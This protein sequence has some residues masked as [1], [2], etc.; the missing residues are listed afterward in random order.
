MNNHLA[1]NVTELSTTSRSS[2]LPAP[3][4]P[5]PVSAQPTKA[6]GVH[7]E[8]G[9]ELLERARARHRKHGEVPYPMHSRN[10]HLSFDAINHILFADIV[11][12]MSLQKLE[13]PPKRVLDLGCGS[14]TWIIAAANAWPETTFV[15]FDVHTRQPN[16]SLLKRS[17]LAQRIEWV[18][19]NFLEFLPFADAEFDFVRAQSIGLGVPEDEWQNVIDEIVRVLKP[20][21][22]LE[23]IEEDILFPSPDTPITKTP[24]ASPTLRGRMNRSHSR[25]TQETVHSEEEES[26][27][28]HSEDNVPSE[29]ARSMDTISGA[30][31]DQRDHSK[32]KEAFMQMLTSRFI[33]PQ[34]LT[35]LPFYLQAAFQEV[36]SLPVMRL[37]LPPPSRVVHPD[38]QS[39][40]DDYAS[41]QISLD[42]SSSAT[43]VDS[44]SMS[45]ASPMTL[46]RFFDS[47][48]TIVLTPEQES[49][50]TR[51]HLGRLV[52]MMRACKEAIWVE[53]EKLHAH[54]RKTPN[55][56]LDR[57]DFEALFHNWECDM[58][59]RCG[60]REL[61]QS[62]LRWPIPAMLPKPAWRDWRDKGDTEDVAAFYAS[63]PP[64][65]IRSLRGFVC[66]RPVH[67]IRSEPIP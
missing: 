13:A 33:N 15:G 21:G 30:Q 46:R 50:K 64:E 1:L 4:T 28:E 49:L 42:S 6:L 45:A 22:S 47:S 36:Q 3:N 34:V 7:K 61:I 23:I 65:L 16:L 59:D 43:L 11:G 41:S 35:V 66:K 2:A 52:E 25:S 57:D 67:I 12:G 63:A 27:K 24:R 14:G 62:S 20:G 31:R 26:G 53:Y 18:H 58:Q 40:S 51:I 9:F 56:R 32:L 10:N 5:S 39:D 48:G 60:M 8:V 44:G 17:D 37:Y 29:K 54:E 38:P 19:G 55:S